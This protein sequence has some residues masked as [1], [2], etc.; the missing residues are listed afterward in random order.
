MR[1]RVTNNFLKDTEYKEVEE[2]VF[3]STQKG[4]VVHQQMNG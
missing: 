2:Y 3:Y 1:I 4:P